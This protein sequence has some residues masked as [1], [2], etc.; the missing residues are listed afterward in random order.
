MEKMDKLK[1]IVE[2]YTEADEI[3]SDSS[4][5]KDLS[6]SSFDIV[7]IISDIKDELG[8]ELSP[9][10]FIENNTIGKMSAYLEKI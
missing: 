8:K 7:C 6:L 10:D 5:R 2:N 9:K 3:T 1:E 4:F